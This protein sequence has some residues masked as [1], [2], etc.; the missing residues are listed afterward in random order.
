MAFDQGNALAWGKLAK[1][2]RCK[3]V[4]R[5]LT[6][7]VRLLK[8]VLCLR[9]WPR[10]G[11]HHP[12]EVRAGQN[13]SAAKIDAHVLMKGAEACSLQ[14]LPCWSDMIFLQ[15]LASK[16]SVLIHADLKPILIGSIT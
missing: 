2:E 3:A 5:S 14:M 9:V 1:V 11:V 10:N 16:L 4:F 8:A 7:L 6:D 15:R 13:F 12:F